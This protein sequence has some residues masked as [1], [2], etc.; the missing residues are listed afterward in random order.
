MEE[1]FSQN[2]QTTAVP[3]EIVHSTSHDDVE[4]NKD[5]AAL[6][7]VWVLSVAVFF[8]KKDSPFVRFHAKQGMVLFALSIV[9]WSV[10]LVGKLLEL[11]VLAFCAMGFIAAAQGLKKD[12]PF[13]GPAARGDWKA[14]RASWRSTVHSIVETWKR[15]RKQHQHAK[16]PAEQPAPARSASATPETVVV[17][18]ATPAEPVIVPPAPAATP[19]HPSVVSSDTP[20][21]P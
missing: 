21:Q 3:A 13:V 8:L 19:G 9:F 18:P 20:P 17:P 4:E 15:F 14:L 11:V 1:Q 2:Q 10:P 16:A 5:I 12:V 7:Y 6:S